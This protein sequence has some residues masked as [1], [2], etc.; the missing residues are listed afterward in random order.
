VRRDR[1]LNVVRLCN[2]VAHGNAGRGPVCEKIRAYSGVDLI[3]F[4]PVSLP[5]MR[6]WRTGAAELSQG[7]VP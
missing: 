1:R 4:P 5:M 7:M 2:R 3:S 6:P